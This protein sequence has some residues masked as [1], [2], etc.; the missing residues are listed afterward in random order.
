MNYTEFL[1]NKIAVAKLEGFEVKREDLPQVLMD[2]QKDAVIW[3]LRGGCR[4]IFAQF[5]LG[6]TADQLAIMQQIVKKFPDGGRTLIVI[7]LGVK[8]EFFRDAK[9]LFGMELEYVRTD[10]E[11]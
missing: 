2:H 8:Q 3:A 11:A 9:N 4:A 10:E 5:G 6:K 7:P 1:K